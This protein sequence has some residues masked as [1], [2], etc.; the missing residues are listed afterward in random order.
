MGKRRRLGT[1]ERLATGIGRKGID[2]SEWPTVDEGGL[3]AERADQ[4]LRRKRGVDLYLAGESSA[5]IKKHTGYS[6]ANIYRLV[7]DRC[8]LT[9]SDGRLWG[10]RGLVPHLRL[11]PY[12]RT[13]PLAPN[14]WGKGTSGAL[15]LLF[16]TAKGAELQTRF[17]SQILQKGR[18]PR[19]KGERIPK[20]DLIVWF[21]AQAREIYKE[22]AY[23]YWPFNVARQGVRT[24]AKYIDHVLDSNPV[25]ARKVLGGPE[26]VKKAKAGDGTERLIQAVFGRVEGD[27]HH[28]DVRCV[29]N[30]P[31]PA[32]GWEPILI[33]RIWVV[34]LIEVASRCVLG[35]SI[36]IRREA[37][38]EDVLR[39][40]RSA[41]SKWTPRKLVYVDKGYHPGAGLPSHLGDK[42]VGLCWDE[43]SVDGALANICNRVESNLSRVVDAR[44]LKPQD[45]NSFSSRRSLDDRPYIESFFRNFRNLHKLSASTGS[46]PSERK[47]RDP[48]KAA[49]ESNFQ[50]EYLEELLDVT[51]ANYNSTP[52][53][54]LSHRSPLKQLEYLCSRPGVV[55]RHADAGEVARLLCPRKLCVVHASGK[56]KTGA[57]VIFSNASYSSSW[58]QARPDL[59][60]EEI[61]VFLENDW[62]A[63]FATASTQSGVLLGP[64]KARPP[65]NHSPHTLYMRSAIRALDAKKIIHLSKNVDPI[66]VL[67]QTA[68]SGD[69]RKLATHP[70]YLDA[71][72]VFQEFA[73]RFE[74]Q[75]VE[76]TST[77]AKPTEES[78]SNQNPTLP[79]SEPGVRPEVESPSVN[80][81]VRR[82]ALNLRGQS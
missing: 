57:F 1:V 45:P 71:R 16:S 33:H 46:K 6:R 20:Q 19:L 11:V 49:V 43:F 74:E 70:A 63:R 55:L 14:E 78:Q 72:R 52:H 36:S 62:D 47:G 53:S 7:S 65:W 31:S 25:A 68:E 10:W 67:V 73:K 79:G 21:L 24:I 80:L 58:L 61:W 82:K 8:L 64:L 59:V 38:A 5:D 23:Q 76:G 44:I 3:S 42:Y 18:T 27:A 35:Y 34:V 48:E 26:A 29:I 41:L 2:V 28:T 4:F 22:Q 32:G 15:Q 69:D 56:A 66:D 9:H 60:G 75:S 13:K 40:V 50:L 39:A 17:E 37:S 30:V 81:P 12:T 77:N 54:S 51:I